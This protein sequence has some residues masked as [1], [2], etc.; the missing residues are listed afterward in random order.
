MQEH[1][2]TLPPDYRPY[3]GEIV[4]IADRG[5]QAVVAQIFPTKRGDIIEI[6]PFGR[7]A[8]PRRLPVTELRHPTG[9]PVVERARRGNPFIDFRVGDTV[10]VSHITHNGKLICRRTGEVVAVN[11]KTGRVSVVGAGLG[12]RVAFTIESRRLERI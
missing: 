1:T 8:A 7:N 9:E 10:R 12:R 6:Q 11:T 5:V 4:E 3:V 2:S